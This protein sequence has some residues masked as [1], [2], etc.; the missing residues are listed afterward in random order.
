MA[1]A[2]H[3]ALLPIAVLV[4]LAGAAAA[5]SD[6]ASAKKSGWVGEQSDGYVGL[7]IADAPADA[8]ALVQRI[9]DG[10]RAEYGRIAQANGLSVDTVAGEA[11]LKLIDRAAPGE[12]VKDSTGRWKKK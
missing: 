10:R 7:V 8:K 11:G 3:R 9:N 1:R 6:L 4:A 2:L 5:A 12:Y